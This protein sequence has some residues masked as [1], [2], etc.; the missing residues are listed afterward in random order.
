MTQRLI[1]TF[2]NTIIPPTCPG[3][4]IPVDQDHDICPKCWKSLEFIVLPFCDNCAE[5]LDISGVSE[6]IY[7]CGKCQQTPPRFSQT[8]ALFKYN[9]LAR[10]LILG[11]KHGN[12]THLASNLSSK[13]CLHHSNYIQDADIIIPVPLH[14][15]RLLKRGYNQASLLA[16]YIARNCQIPLQTNILLRNRRTAS[17]GNYGKKARLRNVQSAFTL[18]DKEKNS[19]ANKT[20]LLVDDVMASGATLNECSKVLLTANAKKVKVLVIAKSTL[21]I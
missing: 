17:Q 14:W 13:A 6:E 16:K 1:K 19:I 18:S 4:H 10:H 3:C 11:L 7:T 9:G 8:R 21:I 12:A 5:P 20:V 15:S 2:L